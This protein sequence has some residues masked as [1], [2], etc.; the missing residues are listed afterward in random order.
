MPAA[1]EF[2]KVGGPVG[3]EEVEGEFDAEEQ[4]EA[5]GDEAVSGEVEIDAETKD[6]AFEPHM[7]GIGGV[8]AKKRSEV[9]EIV[10]YDEFVS[11]AEDDPAQGGIEGVEVEAEAGLLDLRE[12]VILALNRSCHNLREEG[13]EV[14]VVEEVW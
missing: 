7:P 13:A 2:P 3:A 9:A 8:N 6:E 11:E 10:C 12:E 1:P 4:T 5:D 14:E